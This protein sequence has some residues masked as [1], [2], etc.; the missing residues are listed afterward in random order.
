MMRSLSSMA[1]CS[2]PVR[3]ISELRV[4]RACSCSSASCLYTSSRKL[5]AERS[6]GGARARRGLSPRPS[7]SRISTSTTFRSSRV[8]EWCIIVWSTPLSMYNPDR[9]AWAATVNNAMHA[10]RHADRAPAMFAARMP[11]GRCAGTELPRRAAR[12]DQPVNLPTQG[13]PLRPRPTDERRPHRHIPTY[14]PSHFIS[15]NKH[16]TAARAGR[17]CLTSANNHLNLL[18]KAHVTRLISY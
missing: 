4:G 8:I 11:A 13:R 7:S 18:L 1:C 16:H 12:R 9:A 15:F 5:G 10:H 17:V 2:S 3:A 6:S 14:L